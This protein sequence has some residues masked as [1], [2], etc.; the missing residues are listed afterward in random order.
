MFCNKPTPLHLTQYPD[1]FITYTEGFNMQTGKPNPLQLPQDEQYNQQ[2]TQLISGKLIHT[3]D[4]L[5]FPALNSSNN[6][7]TIDYEAHINT[8]LD[9]SINHVFKSMSVAELNTL[10][11]ICEVE[12]TQLLT[13]LAMSVKNPQLAGFLLTQNRS[14]FLYVEGSTAWL[15][16]CPHHLSPLYIAD[17]CYDKIPVNYLDTVMYVDP[18]TRQ[19]FEYANQIPCENNPQ[20]VISLDPDPD[21]YYVLTPQ[22]IKKDPPL[23]FEPTQIQTAISPNTFTAQDAGIYSQ[24]ELKHFWNRVL[25]TKHSDNTLQLLGKAISYEFM[26]QQSDNSFPS[27]PYRSLRIGLHDYMLNLTPF[28]SPDWFTDAFI[29]VFGYPCCILTQCGIYVSTAL[30]L[31]YTPLSIHSLVFSVHS[32]FEIYLKNEF[33]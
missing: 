10:H 6:L 20:N 25:F 14:N 19:T 31:Q 15:Y 3:K 17:Q 4:K 33:P 24:K 28:F 11:T 32:L 7:A 22:P 30:F 1:L 8:K 9:Y 21:Q 23:L 29:K 5:L 2:T 26:N 16:D 12:R 18:I 13:I 27:N